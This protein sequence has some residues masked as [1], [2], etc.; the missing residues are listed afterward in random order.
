MLA[1]SRGIEIRTAA[2][3]NS[4]RILRSASDTRCATFPCRASCCN[5][6]VSLCTRSI[7]SASR[8]CSTGPITRSSGSKRKI[9]TNSSTLAVASGGSTGSSHPLTRR[10]SAK[11]SSAKN[12]AGSAY[13]KFRCAPNS[14]KFRRR[15]KYPSTTPGRTPAST[16]TARTVSSVSGA[17]PGTTTGTAQQHSQQTG[18]P[19]REALEQSPFGAP[20]RCVPVPRFERHIQQRH[21]R[22]GPMPG[23]EKVS[24]QERQP[25]LRR[26]CPRQPD[27]Q[28]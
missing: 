15:K 4:S 5:S 9:S 14:R 7:R 28:R 19:R 6:T 26:T 3:P 8:R 23:M 25:I 16:V 17:I 10:T 21:R 2:K 18:E 1:A 27:S 22:E 11:Y 20:L 13:I 12:V 24:R